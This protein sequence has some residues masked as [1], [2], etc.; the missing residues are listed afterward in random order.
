M[1]KKYKDTSKNNDY[2]TIDDIDEY[3][4]GVVAANASRRLPFVGN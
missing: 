4:R 1:S 2:N 3:L